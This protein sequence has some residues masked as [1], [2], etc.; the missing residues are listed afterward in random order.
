VTNSMFFRLNSTATARQITIS[1]QIIGSGTIGMMQNGTLTLDNP[2]NSFSGF[3]SIGGVDVNILGTNYT[4]TSTL[5][6]TLNASGDGSLGI[7]SSLI[8][9]D[10][11]VIRV[12]YDWIT[13]GSV[14][15]NPN[16]VTFLDT[17]WT[18]GSLTINGSSLGVGTYDYAF[19]SSTYAG[20][21]DTTGAGGSITVVPEPGS[22]GLTVAAL[23]LHFLRR[24]RKD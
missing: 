7:N 5:V 8:A 9:S 13:Q 12:G 10:Y 16:S 18:V 4:N 14:T 23:G 19:L 20:Y 21:F 1:S 3:W 6:S 11:S 22:L 15:L 24:R 17:N 2:N